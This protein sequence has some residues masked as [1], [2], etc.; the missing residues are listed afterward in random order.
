MT[1]EQIEELYT[2][3]FAS[4]KTERNDQIGALGLGSKSPFAYTDMFTIDSVRD[5][6]KS[7]YSAFLDQAGMPTY[8]L[9]KSEKTTQHSG[10][11]IT[12]PVPEGDFGEFAIAAATVLWPFDTNRPK[13]TGATKLFAEY[14]NDYNTSTPILEGRGW[15]IYK[16][17]PGAINR[18]YH[19]AAGATV[20]MGNILYPISDLANDQQFRD[21]VAYINI[22]LVLEMPLGSCDINPSREELSYDQLTK[23]NIHKALVNTHKELEKQASEKINSSATVWEAAKTTREYFSTILRDHSAKIQFTY[24]GTTYTYGQV[25][26]TDAYAFMCNYESGRGGEMTVKVSNSSNPMGKLEV[27]LGHNFLIVVAG[28][29]N[30]NS[31]YLR[32]RIKLYCKQQKMPETI[33][34]IVTSISD[35]ALEQLGNPPVVKYEDLPKTEYIQRTQALKGK[36]RNYYSNNEVDITALPSKVNIYIIDY[37]KQ[38]AISEKYRG[39]GGRIYGKKNNEI[40]RAMQYLFRDGIVPKAVQKKIYVVPYKLFDEL[41]LAKNKNWIS[42]ET[43]AKNAC[44]MLLRRYKDTY[45]AAGREEE[46]LSFYD[47]VL[48]YQSEFEKADFADGSPMKTSLELLK[49]LQASNKTNAKTYE[50]AKTVLD[51]VLRINRY[52]DLGLEVMEI[53]SARNAEKSIDTIRIFHNYPMIAYMLADS[54]YN[55][56]DL[57]KNTLRVD[58]GNQQMNNVDREHV[59]AMVDVIKYIKMVD[60]SNGIG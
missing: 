55:Q 41:G 27:Q 17:Y 2:G 50:V 60:K 10:V 56:L 53:Q 45:I 43:L 8:M 24:K 34:R 57:N 5:G 7:T 49:S 18:R 51:S 42:F 11:R 54:R 16:H 46:T 33:I 25:M 48:Q 21:V 28:A 13:V 47:N 35:E 23:D 38:Y 58:I 9:V 15:K 3:Y 32:T 59:K 4:S 19:Y 26:A 22:P 39:V 37:R 30:V 1:P 14:A 36:V 52:I 29:K 6:V 44:S 12:F 31:Q 20:K 40:G